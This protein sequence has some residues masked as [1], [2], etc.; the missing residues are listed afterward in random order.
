MS[1]YTIRRAEWADLDQLVGLLLGLQDH[2]EASNP[3]LWRMRPEARTN[4]KGQ[5]ASRLTASGVNAIL[6]EHDRDGVVAI[7]FGRILTSNRYEPSR[8]GSV[9][10]L[11][12]CTGHRRRGIARR[13]TA[14]LCRFFA[15]EGVTDLSLR[16]VAGNE[17]AARFWAAIGFSPRIVTAGASLKT[18]EDRLRPARE[19]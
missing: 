8:T 17:E 16:Y 2:I 12:V 19:P 10:Q 15:E 13:L 18:V 1:R 5:I 9:D 6:A 4:L 7:V 11:F 3:D 14:E